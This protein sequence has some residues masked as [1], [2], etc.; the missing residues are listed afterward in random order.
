M[1]TPGGIDKSGRPGFVLR[2][3]LDGFKRE[4]QA[5]R[6]LM[7]A[8]S[9]RHQGR[10]AV[11]S[12]FCEF[13]PVKEQQAHHLRAASCFGEAKSRAETAGRIDPGSGLDQCPASRLVP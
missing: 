2:V 4:Q 8:A 3:D 13:G 6:L 9:R 7:P 5:K 12:V 10:N 1:A 11:D